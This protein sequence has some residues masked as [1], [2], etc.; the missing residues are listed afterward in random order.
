MHS[1]ERVVLIRKTKV[2]TAIWYFF[3]GIK[4]NS[5]NQNL[6]FN[7]RKVVS[8]IGELTCIF[9]WIKIYGLIFYELCIVA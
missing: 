2:R 8:I 3:N 9:T 7:S 4:K 5:K 6:M 1:G